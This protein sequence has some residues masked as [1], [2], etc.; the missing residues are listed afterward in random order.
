MPGYHG[1]PA[2]QRLQEVAEANAAAIALTPGAC[3]TGR[4][5]GC[6]D[7]EGYGWERIAA[8]LACDGAFGFRLIPAPRMPA[9]AARLA[10]LGFRLDSWDVFRAERAEALAA[11]GA[12]V[13]RGLPDGLVDLPPPREAEGAATGAIQALMSAAGVVPFSGA[14]LVGAA[15]PAVTVAIGTPDGAPVA[16]AHAYLPHNRFS[17]WHGHAW[18]GL[19]AVDAARRGRGLGAFINARMILA[20]FAATEATHVYELVS[21]TNAP[22]RRMVAACGLRPEP[23]LACGLATPTDVGRLTR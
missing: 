1:T 23:D 10:A 4:G 15:G 9:I 21:A 20:L 16:A 12:I 22:S 14:L 19:V 5:R 6:D 18:G 11:A 8:T 7:P 17:P 3:Q 2:Q 13:A